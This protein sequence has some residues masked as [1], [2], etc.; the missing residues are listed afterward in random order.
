MNDFS[1]LRKQLPPDSRDTFDLGLKVVKNAIESNEPFIALARLW[2]EWS[3]IFLEMQ[4]PQPPMSAMETLEEASRLARFPNDHQMR[5]LE[6][7]GKH[8]GLIVERKITASTQ[9]RT[10]RVIYD[11]ADV[12]MLVAEPTMH[13]LEDV[14]D[15]DR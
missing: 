15:A 11:T 5:A 1:L 7:L 13:L 12:P 9:E 2:L 4:R 10:V 14:H 3:E 6:F 8:H